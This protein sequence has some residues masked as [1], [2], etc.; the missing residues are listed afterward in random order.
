MATNRSVSDV[1]MYK[2]YA[3]QVDH[4]RLEVVDLRVEVVDL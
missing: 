3:S 2:T 1:N 4:L